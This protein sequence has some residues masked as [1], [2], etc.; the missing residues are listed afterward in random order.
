M[1]DIILVDDFYKKLVN[2]AVNFQKFNK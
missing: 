2:I 1:H